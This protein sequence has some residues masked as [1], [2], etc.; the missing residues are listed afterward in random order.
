LNIVFDNC[1]GQNKNN[2]VLKMVAWLK[3]MGYFKKVNFVFLVVGHTKN[4]ADSLFNSLKHEYRKKNLFTMQ[5]LFKSLNVSDS[6]PVVPTKP[7]DFL[8]YDV[9]TDDVYRDLAGMVKQ[10][11][12]FSCHDDDNETIIRLRESNLNEHKVV[13]HKAVKRTKCFN[14]VSEFRAHCNSLLLVIKCLGLNPY[15]AVELWK[16]Y[17]PVVPVEF[18]D[19][20]LY[21]EPDT[22]IMAKVKDEKLFRAEARKVLKAKKYGEAKEVVEDI[23]FGGAV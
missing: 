2:T 7:E 14:S 18:Q 21:A 19:N 10:N 8:D 22:A 20:A 4:A 1:S 9:L 3:Q 17:R 15:K 13:D 5:G 16:N 23:A 11:H 6:L 12:M